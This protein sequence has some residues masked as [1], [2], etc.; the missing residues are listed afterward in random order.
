[1]NTYHEDEGK[2]VMNKK[3]MRSLPNIISVL[4]KKDYPIREK[5]FKNY[6]LNLVG[7]RKDNPGTNAF[8]DLMAMFWK[9]EGN[10]TLRL[11][12]CTTDPG[13]KT[14]NTPVNPRGTAI[15]K[16]GHY[17]NLWNIGL[18]QGK[19]KA[20][21][22]INDITVYRDNNKDG[23]LDMTHGTEQTGLFGI[24]CH[25]ANSNGQSI[26][27]GGWSAGCQVLQNQ[28]INNPDNQ[29]VKVFEFDYFMHLCELKYKIWN[30]Y[31]SY[32]LINEKDFA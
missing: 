22:Q 13:L 5:D 28:Q 16:E 29:M 17:P 31:F 11:F 1:M 32:S 18:H 4:K 14:L 12:P 19:Y 23:V 9:F 10:W 25:R 24:N 7:I 15:V 27:V 21:K 8:D 2:G 20:L 26:Q 30:D 6:N 3:D